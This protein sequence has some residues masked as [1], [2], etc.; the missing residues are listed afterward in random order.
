MN[1]A[2]SAILLALIAFAFIGFALLISGH[3]TKRAVSRV[4]KILQENNAIGIQQA[5]SI[6]DLGL[7][8]PNLLQRFTQA[9]DYKQSALRILIKAEI[10]RVT[11][12][13]KL[14]LPQE[15]YDELV[16]K[17]FLKRER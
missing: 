8:P 15:K 16:A 3:M 5:K 14:F 13:G 9:R 11:E 4:L 6:P 17:G 12:D 1:G 7:Q 10:I 2:Y